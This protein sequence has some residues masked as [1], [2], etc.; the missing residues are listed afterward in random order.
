[1]QEQIDEFSEREISTR[2][3]YDN[4][5]NTINDQESATVSDFNLL[6]FRMT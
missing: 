2:A 3:M 1:M 5:I 4:I 6:T